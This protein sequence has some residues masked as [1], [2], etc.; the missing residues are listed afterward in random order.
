MNAGCMDG[1]MDKLME[2]WRHNGNANPFLS[3]LM[4]FLEVGGVLTLL[5]IVSLKSCDERH[6]AEALRLLTLV[7]RKGRQ[8]KEII[9]ESYGKTHD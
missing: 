7:A 2:G 6:K 4:E 8:Y 9:C 3:F 5:E 1:H